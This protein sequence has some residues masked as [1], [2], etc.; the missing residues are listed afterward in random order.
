[1]TTIHQ[2]SS[3][4][5]HSFDKLLLLAEGSSVFFGKAS[6]AM[7]YFDS[8][9]FTPMFATNPADFMLDLANGTTADVALPPELRGEEKWSSR[10][11]TEQASGVKRVRGGRVTHLNLEAKH[12][13][14]VLHF[15][16]VLSFF[17]L[18]LKEMEWTMLAE[19]FLECCS[20]DVQS[21]G[22]G[23]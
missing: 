4:L 18:Y 22:L 23:A 14:D 19:N 15:T 10:P 5:F 1:M 7:G 20:D 9:G 16:C 12:V 21:D 17:G 8:I 6:E 3:R 11:A 2:P 13:M